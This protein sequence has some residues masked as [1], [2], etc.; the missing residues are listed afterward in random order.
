[1]GTIRTPKT[2]RGYAVIDNEPL[3]DERFAWDERGMLAYLYSL[4]DDWEINVR[5]LI[6]QTEKAGKYK[7]GRDGVY[8]ILNRLIIFGYM[9]RSQENKAGTGHLETVYQLYR[10]TD[11]NPHFKNGSQMTANGSSVNG[12]TA[13]GSSVNGSTAY[14]SSVHLQS[15]NGYKT[16][17]PQSQN[18]DKRR[19]KDKT[20][21]PLPPHWRKLDMVEGRGLTDEQRPYHIALLGLFGQQAIDQIDRDLYQLWDKNVPIDDINVKYRAMLKTLKRVAKSVKPSTLC[22]DWTGLVLL[23]ATAD[24]IE[25]L[26]SPSLDHSYWRQNGF[27]GKAWPS[28]VLSN[29]PSARE[30]S[31]TVVTSN[32][33]TTSADALEQSRMPDWML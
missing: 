26:F 4:P 19:R 14:G 24:E 13:N 3:Q 9:S 32:G 21:S 30:W 22:R 15:T 2:R 7:T 10:T 33:S 20:A 5:H 18:G 1:M 16:K 23:E 8:R 6:R 25:K 11:E 27:N 29:L 31:L 12:S 28:Q 17:T